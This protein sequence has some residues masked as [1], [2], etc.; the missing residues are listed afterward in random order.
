M[1][2]NTFQQNES[3]VM[4]TSYGSVD[5]LSLESA[6]GIKNG[7]LDG[8][9]GGTKT[10]ANA[11]EGSAAYDTVN[12]NAGDVISFGYIFGTDDYIPFQD[13][14]FVSFNG[15]VQ[16]L[17]TV[18]VECPEYGEITDV[19]NYVVTT[20]DLNGNF[21]GI[22]TLGAGIVDVEDTYV[23]SYIEVFDFEIS[24]DA[25]EG[26]TSADGIVDGAGAYAISTALQGGE[27]FS[28]SNTSYC[29]T[30]RY[31]WWATDNTF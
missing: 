22:V 27:N 1:V 26:D 21:S 13:F 16:N 30:F 5:Q 15:K 19:F 11:T 18:G 31:L 28:T 12:V 6:L 7:E 8:T 10:A 4:S 20:D 3:M 25:K 17:A 2:G 23:D 24:G 14:A 9:L 29:K